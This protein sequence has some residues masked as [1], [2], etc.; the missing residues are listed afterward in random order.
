[1]TSKLGVSASELASHIDVHRTYV[2]NLVREGT[3]HRLK[4]GT[5]DLNAC[6]IAYIRRIR[7]AASNIAP[8]KFVDAKVRNQQLQA[9]RLEMQL[10]QARGELISM[11]DVE[12][13]TKDAYAALYAELGGVPAACTRDLDSR[14]SVEA[15]ID[16]ALDRLH[17]RFDSKIRAL[18]QGQPLITDEN[19]ED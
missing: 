1:M 7:A 10:A 3:F 5:F 6:T 8:T 17:T 14:N 19:D 4:D 12:M 9:E 15:Q 2:G 13:L 16:A 11:T 18:Q